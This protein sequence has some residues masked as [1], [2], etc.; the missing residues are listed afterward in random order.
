M[1]TLFDN[2]M[3][4]KNDASTLTE[5]KD[6][7]VSVIILLN[8]NFNFS[9]SRAPYDI[10]LYGKKMWEW[11]ALACPNTNIKTTVC[12]EE[13]EILT[14]IKPYLGNQKWTIVLYSD[15]PLISGATL[16]DILSYARAKDVNV[17]NLPKGYV[18]NTEYIKNTE[19]LISTN[20]TNFG[21]KYD[22]FEV[23]SN[24]TLY[25]AKHILK[26]RILDYHIQNGVN[27]E[28]KQSTFIDAEVVIENGAKI[29]HNTTLIGQTYIGKN[30]TIEPNSIIKDSVIS[31]KCVVKCSYIEQSRISE[32]M[33]V[34]PFEKIINKSN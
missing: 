1:E 22:F 24:E 12:T 5:T 2:E 6:N 15:T 25:E 14:L 11:V 10:P 19:S 7:D 26:N 29:E 3:I 21:S 8:K 33:I 34:G 13:S 16:Q 18:F 28:D 23:N 30:C 32:N 31:D 20:I 27:I 9:V 17:L 4:V